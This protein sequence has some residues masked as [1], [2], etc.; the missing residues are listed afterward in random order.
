MIP[1]FMLWLGLAGI[2]HLFAVNLS[3]KL[4]LVEGLSILVFVTTCGLEVVDGG[5][6]NIPLYFNTT[7]AW[8]AVTATL[9][10]LTT[11]MIAFK[12]LQHRRALNKH[13]LAASANGLGYISL[14]SILTESAILYTIATAAFIPMIRLNIPVQIWW[15]QVVNSLAVRVFCSISSTDCLTFP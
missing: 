13:G 9:Q 1:P 7:T 14:A 6:A 2:Y 5:P 11:G 4:T 12:L 8:Y 10:V 15:G 3:R